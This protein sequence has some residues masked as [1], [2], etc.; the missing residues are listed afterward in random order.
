MRFELN[1]RASIIEHK[2]EVVVH[3]KSDDNNTLFSRL[4]PLLF[5]DFDDTNCTQFIFYDLAW[6][7]KLR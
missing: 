1:C 5:R 6:A 4:D 3:Q 2:V 7:L